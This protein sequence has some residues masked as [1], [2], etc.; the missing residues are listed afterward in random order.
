MEF[1]ESGARKEALKN[2]LYFLARLYGVVSG[3]ER[4]I[5][6]V[7]FLNNDNPLEKELKTRDDIDKLIDGHKFEGMTRMGA[8]L[9]RRILKPF[10]YQEPHV[11]GT[12][13]K[14]SEKL[15]RPLLIMVI[16]DGKVTIPPSFKHRFE[17]Q[18]TK[19]YVSWCRLKERSQDG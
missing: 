18:G 5:K 8:G 16:T 7:R 14:L 12:P 2:V 3:G 17:N 1:V 15:E 4:G 6:A 9:M 19:L 13:R 10:V 11:Q